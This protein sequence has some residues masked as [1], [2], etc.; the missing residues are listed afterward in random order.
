MVHP[1]HCD[2]PEPSAGGGGS[3]LLAKRFEKDSGECIA[4]QISAHITTRAGY[5]PKLDL[6]V[7]PADEG[8]AVK[9]LLSLGMEAKNVSGVLG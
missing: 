6:T 8:Q 7:M 5:I 2:P 1:A 9:G 3:R 4:R